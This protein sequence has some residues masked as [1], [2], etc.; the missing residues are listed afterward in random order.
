MDSFFWA[1]QSLIR[2]VGNLVFYGTI[3]ALLTGSIIYA[4]G[5]TF[6]ASLGRIVFDTA[7][8]VPSLCIGNDCK[9]AWPTGGSTGLQWSG[10]YWAMTHD[11]AWS[12][13]LSIA[14]AGTWRV[15]SPSDI[16]IGRRQNGQLFTGNKFYWSSSPYDTNF[17]WS[18]FAASSVW[19]Y[20]IVGYSVCSWG[21]DGYSTP[22]ALRCV[23]NS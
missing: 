1:L 10:E 4:A 18:W 15:P 8:Q 16:E 7:V 2:T 17:F 5:S 9:S 14:P 13:C 12:T 23:S 22:M 11:N 20:C 6:N 3:G 21:G 19:D